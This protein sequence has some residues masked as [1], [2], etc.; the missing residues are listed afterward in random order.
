MA[1][2]VDEALKNEIK[3][4][5]IREMQETVVENGRILDR[6]VNEIVVEYTRDLDEYVGN[7]RDLLKKENPPTDRQ[8]DLFALN[9]PVLLYYVGS[10]QETLGISEDVS[11]SLKQE[12]YNKAYESASG[13]IADKTASAELFSQNA[14]LTNLIYSRAYKK[15]KNR[16]EFA[17]E[18]LQSVKKVLSR[19]INDYSID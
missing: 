5:P 11:K 4:Q 1:K 12:I 10:R 18:I 6:L 7:I 9:I 19:R 17:L 13:T 8:L 15:L 14:T 2:K 16:I 3:L